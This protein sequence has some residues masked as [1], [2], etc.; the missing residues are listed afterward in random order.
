M[1]ELYEDIDRL[2]RTYNAYRK[3]EVIAELLSLDGELLKVR[4]RGKYCVLY[5]RVKSWIDDFKDVASSYGIKLEFLGYED[6]GI[7]YEVGLFRI[8]KY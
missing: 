7:N 1:D 8:I 3:S 4:F 6:K 5:S 2:L